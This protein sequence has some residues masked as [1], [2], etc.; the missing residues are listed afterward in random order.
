MSS[1]QFYI[2][3]SGPPATLTYAGKFVISVNFNRFTML[4]TINMEFARAIF[5]H[6]SNPQFAHENGEFKT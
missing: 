3:T 1:R 5:R 6:Y 4:F 2:Y